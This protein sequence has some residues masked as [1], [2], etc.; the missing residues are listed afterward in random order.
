M[1]GLKIHGW[2]P[3]EVVLPDIR[4]EARVEDPSRVRAAEIV[5]VTFARG[6]PPTLLVYTQHLN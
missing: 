2:I 5:V 3:G 4:L 6:G 1:K